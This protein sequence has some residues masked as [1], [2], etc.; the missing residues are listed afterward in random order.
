[1]VKRTV[2]PDCVNCQRLTV[3]RA[4]LIWR[5]C[6]SVGAN[7]P[8]ASLRSVVFPAPF[9]PTMPVHAPSGKCARCAAEKR[10]DHSR[11]G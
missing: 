5:M 8:A 1:M 3:S 4:L 2:L 11:I 6:P 9:A 7:A 10:L